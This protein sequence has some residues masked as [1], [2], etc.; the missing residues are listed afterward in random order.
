[1]P[2]VPWVLV[3]LLACKSDWYL[4][5]FYSRH[6][7]VR[8]SSLFDRICSSFFG[9]DGPTSNDPFSSFFPLCSSWFSVS[10][11]FIFLHLYLV[12]LPL[13][14]YPFVC[15][16]VCVFLFLIF[17]SSLLSLSYPCAL[18]NSWAT[19]LRYPRDTMTGA[20]G[21]GRL[22]VLASDD[23]CMWKVICVP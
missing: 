14:A 6:N 23:I 22:S 16:C 8:P 9:W 19:R 5:S 20:L 11:L 7:Q 17:F 1:M 13:P 3:A 12:H 18:C 2:W 21:E 4:I 10:C 15:V